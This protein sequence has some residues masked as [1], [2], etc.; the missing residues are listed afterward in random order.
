MRLLRRALMVAVL[1]TAIGSGEALG[2]DYCVAPA[3]GCT[4]GNTFAATG[5]G[6]QAALN[7]AAGTS[8]RVL[9]G[10][11]VYTAPS[12]S[13]FSYNHPTFT[14][15]II[16]AGSG[17]TVLTGP[18]DT[19]TVLCLNAAAGAVLRDVG[20]VILLRAAAQGFLIALNLHGATARRIAVTSNPALNGANAVQVSG[21]TLE[22]STITLPL[23][24]P[25]AG[26]GA[27]GPG[28]TVRNTTITATKPLNI[29]TDNM[30]FER[31][32]AT[33]GPGGNAVSVR[34]ANARISDSVIV[35]PGTSAAVVASTGNSTNP[36]LRL[37][38]DTV[39]GT[40]GATSGLWADGTNAGYAAL[41]DVHNTIIRGFTHARTRVLGGAGTAATITT[42]YS[43]YD[44]AGDQ[45]LGT[46][47]GSSGSTTP[48]P[49]VGDV[50]VDPRFVDPAGGDYRLLKDSPLIDAGDPA[51]PFALESPID[52]AGRPRS[53]DGNGDCTARTDLGALEFHDVPTAR[54][55]RAAAAVAGEPV[56]FDGST[57]CDPDG[58]ALTYAWT[59]D[60]GGSAGGVAASHV[61]ASPGAHT[62]TLTVTDP[63]ADSGS[64]V[65]AFDVA[66]APVGAPA[67]GG[68]TPALLDTT[69]PRLTRLRAAPASFAVRSAARRGKKA[70]GGTMLG[71]TLSEA[72]KVTIALQRE[73]AGHR[74]GSR[75]VAGAP[76]RGSGAKPC[77]ALRTAGSITA[78]GRAG[79][80]TIAFS[81]RIGKRALAP[82]RYRASATAADAAGN[83]TAAAVTLRLRIVR[84][85]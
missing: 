78:A 62:A 17:L 72:A 61:F 32:R 50:N 45:V 84:A 15:Q 35:Q 38:H 70:K 3:T 5:A 31:V 48:F 68:A 19:A 82:A 22:D 14:P 51:A 43:D 8:D 39:I 53:L 6:V 71:F 21:A 27:N 29:N 74:S 76:A 46:V 10:A 49:G 12:T 28:G 44:P 24:G 42:S 63:G 40:S 54:A 18:T 20:I 81:G 26:I 85:R 23:S 57:S 73:V 65:L 79:A 60:D 16:G 67:P 59:F 58:N 11:A 66:A 41:I 64:V 69:A 4:V 83:K 77:T 30:T 47:A 9:L 55:T 7:A 36:T 56:A 34:G 25:I 33:A 13:G 80:N 37:D 52:L 75:C 2:A 1:A